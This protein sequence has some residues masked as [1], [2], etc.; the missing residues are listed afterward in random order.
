MFSLWNRLRARLGVLGPA[1]FL[2]AVVLGPGSITLSTIAGSLY[3]Y[4]LLWV[5]VLTTL[6]MILFTWLSARIGLVTG[7]TLFGATRTRYGSLVARVG[8]L[9]GFLAILAFQAGNTAA[10]GFAGQALFGGSVRWWA[11]GF[12]LLAVGLIYLP[13]LYDRLESLVRV[14]V[15]LMMAT[16]LGTL[17]VVGVDVPAAGR[18]L[19][20][21]FPDP[22]SVFLSLGIAASTFSIVAAVYQSYL[23]REKEWG[24]ERL[25]DENLDSFLGIAIL[26]LMAA[27]ILLTSAGAIHGTADPVFSARGMAR[28][29]EP[30]VGPVAFYLFTVGFLFASLSSLVVNPLIGATLLAD[31]FEANPSMDGPVV[32]RWTAG[33]LAGGLVAVWAFGG[34][35]VE[36]LRIAQGLAVVAFPLLG[37]LVLDISRDEELMAGYVPG[38]AALG[39]GVLGYLTIV[40]M[41]VNY[42]RQIGQTLLGG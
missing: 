5:P 9:F 31:G 3:G 34:S 8:G 36:L 19:V 23:M 27:V 7:R 35:P 32:K 42:L 33:A 30:L 39:A 38:P 18:G 25:E 20:P 29:L 22:E 14:V 2:A 26:G 4:Q 1:L 15:G 11:L 40:G 41:V 16:F 6:F 17:A 37:Y 21:T 24:P 10:I 13:D 12:V 28:Q